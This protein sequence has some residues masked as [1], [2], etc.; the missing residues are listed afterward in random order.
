MMMSAARYVGAAT[1]DSAKDKPQAKEVNKRNTERT[2][3]ETLGGRLNS[4]ILISAAR[5]F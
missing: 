2:Q 5:P 3:I 4:G 1:E